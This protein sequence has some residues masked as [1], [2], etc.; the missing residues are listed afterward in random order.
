MD[1]EWLEAQ[2]AELDDLQRDV[3]RATS[4]PQPTTLLFIYGCVFGFLVAF[5]S[6]VVTDPGAKLALQVIVGA[7]LLTLITVLIAGY[8]T[9][10]RRERR[11]DLKLELIKQRR[12]KIEQ[13]LSSF[14]L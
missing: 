4:E 12:R 10:R 7:N 14:D 13:D 1:R 3:T 6:T 5:A 8:I 11:Q 2:L 9:D